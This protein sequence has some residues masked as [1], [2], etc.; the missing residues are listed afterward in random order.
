MKVALIQQSNTA[1]IPQNINKLE[2]NIR[3]STSAELVVL[4]EITTDF[5]SAKQKMAFRPSKLPR[6][7]TGV[8]VC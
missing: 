1:D 2:E 8:L 7:S 3:S 4:Q 5:T 6:P